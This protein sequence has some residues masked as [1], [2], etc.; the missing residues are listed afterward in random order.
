MC[1]NLTDHHG[2]HNSPSRA[3]VHGNYKRKSIAEKERRDRHKGGGDIDIKTEMVRKKDGRMKNPLIKRQ[4]WLV[5]LWV[6]RIAGTLSVSSTAYIY[7]VPVSAR[8][9]PR[10]P[11]HDN[12]LAPDFVDKK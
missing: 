3:G 8:H 7:G 11:M 4:G 1:F 2:S 12:Y 6:R 5:P 10:L 9:A